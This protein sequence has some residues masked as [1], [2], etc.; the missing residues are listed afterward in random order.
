M[1]MSGL[2]LLSITLAFFFFNINATALAANTVES[3]PPHLV[4]TAKTYDIVVAYYEEDLDELARYLTDLKKTS[5]LSASAKTR[6]IVYSKNEKTPSHEIKS[7]L[8]ATEV[9]YLENTGRELHTYMYHIAKHYETGLADF[10]FYMQA[11]PHHFE[12]LLLPRLNNHFDPRSTGFMPLGQVGPD[13]FD[14]FPR[15]RDIYAMVYGEITPTNHFS[16]LFCGQF[17]VS[18]PTTHKTPQRVFKHLQDMLAAPL[19]HV[20]HDEKHGFFKGPS[21]PSNPIFGHTME[22]AVGLLFHCWQISVVS[23]ICDDDSIKPCQCKQ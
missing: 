8:D 9:V 7:K 15:L 21:T 14:E 6:I 18:R 12:Q 3:P 23:D 13:T 10:T 19:G 22:R 20:L 5:A 1:M 4:S 2:L 17:V 11:H 16:Y